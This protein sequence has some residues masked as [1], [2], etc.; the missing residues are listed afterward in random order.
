MQTAVADATISRAAPQ[1]PNVRRV[2]ALTSNVGDA[3]KILKEDG[4][5]IV[6]NACSPQEADAIAAEMVGSLGWLFCFPVV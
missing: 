6:E 4:C 5:V 3:L 2:D 1:F